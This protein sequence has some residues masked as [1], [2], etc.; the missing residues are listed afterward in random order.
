MKMQS[1]HPHSERGLDPY[2]TPPE[3]TESLLAIEDL[4]HS[5]WE[6]AAGDGAIVKVLRHAGFDVFAS[7][8][9]KY[10]NFECNAIMDYFEFVFTRSHDNV[11][12]ITNPPFLRAVEFAEKALSEVNYVALLLRTNFLESTSRLPFFRSNPPSTV[13]ISSRRLPMMHRFG[14]TGPQAPSNTC[15]AWFIWDYR[16]GRKSIT[17]IDWFDWA[18]YQPNNLSSEL[19]AS[20]LGL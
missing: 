13:W 3:A 9:V 6:P 5:I 16:Q 11:G 7:D 1:S 19:S 20:E 17:V 2:F 10:G 8:I 4:P 12:I 14:W 18:D 15:H